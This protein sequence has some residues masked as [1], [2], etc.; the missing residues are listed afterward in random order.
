MITEQIYGPC[1]SDNFAKQLAKC[2][3]DTD[4]NFNYKPD[5]TGIYTDSA[6]FTV[7]IPEC[8]N[9]SVGYYSEHSYSERQDILHLERLCKSVCLIDWESLPVGES[10]SIGD[11]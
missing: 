1:C 6:Q 9:I 3:N 7:L 10:Q 11:F 8:T 2:L 4:E 5:P